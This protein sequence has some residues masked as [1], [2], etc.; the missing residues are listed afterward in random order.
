MVDKGDIG[1][2]VGGILLGGAAVATGLGVPYV[3]GAAVAGAIGG[4]HLAEP[5]HY[6]SMYP[7]K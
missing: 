3:V 6:K 1:S 4:H 2:L 5:H 7:Y